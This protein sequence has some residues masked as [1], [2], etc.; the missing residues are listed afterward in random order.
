[1]Q[2]RNCARDLLDTRQKFCSI[3]CQDDYIR[4]LEQ[5]IEEATKNDSSHTERLS[6]LQE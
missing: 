2:C 5:I 3:N 4:H 6:H 1:M